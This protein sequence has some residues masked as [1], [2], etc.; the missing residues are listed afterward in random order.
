MLT[1]PLLHYHMYVSST[2]V[3]HATCYLGSNG[4]TKFLESLL[5]LIPFQRTDLALILE[6]YVDIRV[7]S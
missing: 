5:S 6:C 4:S 2:L 1:P 3:T 7:G